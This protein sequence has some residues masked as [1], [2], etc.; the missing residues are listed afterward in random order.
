MGCD[1]CSDPFNFSGDV[2]IDIP[3]WGKFWLVPGT[4][5]N[6]AIIREG[7]KGLILTIEHLKFN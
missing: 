2:W 1:N 5:E 4:I 3:G 6:P 7:P